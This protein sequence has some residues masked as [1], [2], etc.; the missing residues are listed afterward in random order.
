[1][2][3]QKLNYWSYGISYCTARTITKLCLSSGC[4]SKR[5]CMTRTMTNQ[6]ISLCVSACRAD[7]FRCSNGKCIQNEV[8]CDGT[9]DCPN[10]EDEQGCSKYLTI[11]FTLSTFQTGCPSPGSNYIVLEHKRLPLF[12]FLWALSDHRLRCHQVA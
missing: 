3:F 6:R 8:K 10:G 11:N 7:Q 5:V 9:N 4:V 1:M 2:T 12:D